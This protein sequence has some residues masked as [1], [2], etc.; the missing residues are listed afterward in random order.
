MV[1]L[2]QNL[3]KNCNLALAPNDVNKRLFNGVYFVLPIVW[4]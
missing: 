4:T 1:N 2:P 3:I